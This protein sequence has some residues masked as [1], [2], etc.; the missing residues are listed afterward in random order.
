VDR[1]ES[2]ADQMWERVRRLAERMA[3]FEQAEAVGELDEDGRARL[4]SLRLRCARAA[5]RA[6]LADELSDR[7]ADARAARDRGARGAGPPRP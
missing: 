3:R 5:D 6:R 7:V 4:A 2:V 1:S